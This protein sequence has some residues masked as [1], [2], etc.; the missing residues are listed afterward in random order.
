MDA[1][2]GIVPSMPTE[3]GYKPPVRHSS[4]RLSELYHANIPAKVLQVAV[5]GLDG[6]VRQMYALL[7]FELLTPSRTLQRHTPSGFLKQGQG[8]ITM[9]FVLRSFGPAASFQALSTL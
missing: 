3:A 4:K 8:L 7:L 5:R 2:D 6:N 9:C 1:I